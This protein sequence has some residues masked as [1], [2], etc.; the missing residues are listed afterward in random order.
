MKM[1]SWTVDGENMVGGA[2]LHDGYL[3][4]VVQE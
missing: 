3:Y 4:V 1:I 2:N